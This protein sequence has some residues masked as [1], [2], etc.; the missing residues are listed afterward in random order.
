MWLP[1]SYFTRARLPLCWW[2]LSI[3]YQLSVG[4]CTDYLK[5]EVREIASR[6]IITGYAHNNR[7]QYEE[8]AW[9]LHFYYR[10]AKSMHSYRKSGRYLYT[11]L[12]K[13]GIC[14]LFFTLLIRFFF[15]IAN[16]QSY[17]VSFCPFVF[18]REKDKAK[19]R[20]RMSVYNFL[21]TRL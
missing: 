10:C 19:Y 2:T 4:Y 6:T 8:N 7:K 12:G 17:Y 5:D 18:L 1:K 13:H 3:V 15:L 9:N 20:M 21:L 14:F 16:L 11:I